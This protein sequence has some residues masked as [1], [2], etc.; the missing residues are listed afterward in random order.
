[1]AWGRG[2]GPAAHLLLLLNARVGMGLTLRPGQA[3][4]AT[5]RGGVVRRRLRDDFQQIRD[6]TT[7]L[8]IK[9]DR[10]VN[11]LKSSVEK[12]KNDTVHALCTL[13]CGC[14]AGTV[15]PRRCS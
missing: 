9:V 1:M 10:E 13:C 8:E 7:G 14:A 5:V 2:R 12:A 4:E 6:T 11:E 15:C 3:Q